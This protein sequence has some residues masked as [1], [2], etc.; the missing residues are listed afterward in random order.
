MGKKN[1]EIVN[2]KARFEYHFHQSY[3]AG[4]A[5]TG[6]EVKSIKAG[7]ANLKDA[8]CMFW[9]GELIIKNLY[10]A[11]YKFGNIHNHETRRD[12][13][14]LLKRAELKKLDRR[15]REKG[16]TIVPYKIYLN[17]RG[18]IKIEI[19]LA[20]GKKAYDKRQSIKDKDMRRDL[21]RIKKYK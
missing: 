7:N 3:E 13:K 19:A 5:L 8:Y 14:L 1:I 21:D 20:Q 15:V 2:K 12:R 6:T 4:I 10:I 9:K 18:F 11:E 16:L 17:E